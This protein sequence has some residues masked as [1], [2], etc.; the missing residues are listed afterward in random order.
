MESDNGL[1]EGF[2]RLQAL[3]CRSDGNAVKSSLRGGGGVDGA[4]HSVAGKELL[5]ACQTLG[6]CMVG[7]AKITKGYSLPAKH[8]I[9]T[10]GPMWRGGIAGEDKLLANCYK[11][12]LKLASEHGIKSIAFPAISTGAY[13]YPLKEASE[14]AVKTVLQH[15]ADHHYEMK[16]IFCCFDSET[17]GLYKDI[18]A[19]VQGTFV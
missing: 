6:G 17:E 16:V 5:A 3:L 9:H 15:F 7:E 1:H 10:V 8:V 2:A 12:C 4:I 18:L 11:N 13:G 19:S 14:I